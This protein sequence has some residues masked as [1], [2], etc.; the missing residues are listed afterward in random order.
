MIIA[1]LVVR[2]KFTGKDALDF[3]SN[4]GGAVPGTILGI[5]FVM[6]FNK[7]PIA[8]AIA[9]YAILALFYAQIV[10][11]NAAER[12]IILILGTAFGVGLYKDQIQMHDVLLSRWIVCADGGHLYDHTEKILEIT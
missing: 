2:K 9:I 12:I 7:P 10:G 3:T 5:G 6:A 4:L 1:W 8:L 11:K